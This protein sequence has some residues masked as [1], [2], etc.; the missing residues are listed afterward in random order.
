MSRC[1]SAE[2]RCRGCVTESQREREGLKEQD[3]TGVCATAPEWPRALS[4]RSRLTTS[5]AC[6]VKVKGKWTA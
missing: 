6:I 3:N 2:L 4:D 1:V 5:A